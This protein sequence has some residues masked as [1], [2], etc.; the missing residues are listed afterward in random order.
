MGSPKALLRLDDG[1][2]LSV[3]LDKLE[4]LQLPNPTVV[5]GNHASLIQPRLASRN[6]RILVNPHPEQ[7]QISS[8]QLAIR[9]AGQ[10]RGCL[11]WPV[12]QPAVREDVVE[13]LLDLFDGSGALIAMPVCGGRRGHPALFGRRLCREL[14]RSVRLTDSRSSIRTHAGA[15]VR[16]KR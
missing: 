12:D 2:F 7:G 8:M 11:V 13:Q 1:T 3:I 16:L 4:R 10:C 9:N 6:V 14:L 5:L 15:T